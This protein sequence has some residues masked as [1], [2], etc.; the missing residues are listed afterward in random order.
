[1]PEAPGG[2]RFTGGEAADG[3]KKVR[4]KRSSFLPL[5]Q[6]GPSWEKCIFSDSSV[7]S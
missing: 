2:C 3:P 4:H 1:M 5:I 7:S 6:A